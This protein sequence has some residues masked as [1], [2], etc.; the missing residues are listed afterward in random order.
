MMFPVLFTWPKLANEAI[1]V[2]QENNKLGSL[3][4]PMG[5]ASAR[6]LKTPGHRADVST[7]YSMKACYCRVLKRSVAITRKMSARMFQ[8][9]HDLQNTDYLVLQSRWSIQK[10]KMA[11]ESKARNPPTH[12]I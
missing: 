10:K 3:G 8:P 7:S 9:V 5:N 2:T 12:R 1:P 4:L 6:I 11:A